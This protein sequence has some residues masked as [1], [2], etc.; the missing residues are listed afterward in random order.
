MARLEAVPDDSDSTPQRR[1]KPTTT[2]TSFRIS[3][4][5]YDKVKA[6]A[7]KNNSSM[8]QIYHRA[9]A[10][11]FG[12]KISNESW[13]VDEGDFY[14]P[15]E[16]YTASQDKKG[17]SFHMRVNLPKPLGGL[18]Y[19]LIQSAVVPQ[20]RSVEDIARDA[21]YH[22]VKQIARAIDDGELEATVDMAMLHA[23]ELQITETAQHAEELIDAMQ[24]NAA[25][26]WQ[27]D[28]MKALKK[29][30]AERRQ[31][32]DSL[33]E[34]FK[35]DYLAVLKTYEDRIVKEEKRKAKSSRKKQ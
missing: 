11:Y 2:V 29:Y 22:R 4:Y 9:L 13:E 14:D 26:M 18:L 16:F 31:V 32:A 30:L 20:Y 5:W 17:H 8:S 10:E 33:V 34:P 24:T 35:R 3:T 12:Q 1:G 27:R 6:E 21:V 25:M 28:D 7:E 15:N 19:G 23:Q